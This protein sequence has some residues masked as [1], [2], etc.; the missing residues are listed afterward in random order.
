MLRLPTIDTI[1]FGAIGRAAYE[2]FCRIELAWGKQ[3]V[4]KAVQRVIIDGV[5]S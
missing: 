2:K 4:S 1:F 5:N 3:D